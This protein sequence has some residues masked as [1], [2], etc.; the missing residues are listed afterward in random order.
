MYNFQQYRHIQEPGWTLGWTWAK[1]EVIWYMLG[2]QATEQGDCSKFHSGI[3]HSCEKNPTVVDKL[4]GTPYNFQVANC[5]KAGVLSSLAQ[6]PSNA[7]SKFEIT[8]G[9]TGTTSKSIHLPKNFTL[10]TPGPGYTCGPAKIVRP[11]QYFTSDKR[12]ASQA[13]MTWDITCTYSQFVAQRI[14][15]CCVSLSSFYNDTIINCPSCTCGCQ[16]KTQPDSCVNFNYKPLNPYGDINDTGIFWGIKSFNDI[17]SSAGPFGYVQS[18]ILLKKDKSTF[19][20]DQGWAFPRR[21]YFNGDYCV[22]P[23]PDV[24]HVLESKGIKMVPFKLNYTVDLVQG[25]LNFAMDVDMLAH[26]DQWQC[27]GEDNVYEAQDQWHTELRRAHLIPA[28]DYI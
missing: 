6:D 26:F 23:P 18:E 10:K 9:S 21:I 8:V 13:F 22:M 1:E 24:V 27:S 17:L 2:S 14:P 19:T 3:P 7:A 20:M 4:S 28:V 12:R 5:C 16:N 15:T 11:T 25:I